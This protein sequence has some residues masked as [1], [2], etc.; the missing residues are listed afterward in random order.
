MAGEGF[1]A[2]S[3]PTRRRI[4]ELLRDGDKT[5]GELAEHF[6]MTKP[7]ISHHLATLKAA[8]LVDD[9]RR[10]QNIVY[11]LNTTVMQDLIG[12]FMG[13]AH[14]GRASQAGPAAHP[15][16]SAQAAQAPQPPQ[17]AQPPQPS[18][19]PQSKENQ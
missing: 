9:E 16:Q 14:A 12:W 3:D 6:D 15:A 2:L 8:G 7:S 1:K 5:A 11:S 19:L 4:L 17:P 10:G 13:F 18:P